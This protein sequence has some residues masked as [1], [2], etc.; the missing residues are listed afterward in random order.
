MGKLLNVI[1]I[2]AGNRGITYTNIMADMQDKYRVVAVA[3]PIE[4]RRLAVQSRHGIPDERCFEDWRDLLKLGKIAD[5]AVISTMDAFHYEPSMEA[6][7]LNYDILL[8]KPVSPDPEECMKIAQ[9][10]V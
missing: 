9:Y 3:E 1:L 10:A 4:S 6:I 5:A 7:S 8:E 2:G